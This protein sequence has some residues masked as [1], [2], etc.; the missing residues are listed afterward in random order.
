MKLKIFNFKIVNSTNDTALRIIKNTN[1]NYGMIISEKQK[2]GRGQYGKKWISY[3][4]NL[5]VS[6][7]YKLNKINLSLRQL[8]TFNCLLIKKLLQSYYKKRI[9]IK[10]PNDLFINGKKISGILQE[11]IKNFDKTFIIVG[12][13]I[14]LVK[15][16]NISNYPSTNLF[17]LTK[18][19][20]KKKEIEK[21][22][23]LIYEK[24]IPKISKLIKKD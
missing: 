15:N 12:I 8:T 24:S 5:F 1:Y 4:G 23:R 20:F 22:L 9:V 16:P 2:K 14:N 18:V 19:K 7:F 3:K 17:T 13:G 11:K 10:K 21:K 6:I